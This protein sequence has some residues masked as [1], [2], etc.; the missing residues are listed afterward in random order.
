MKCR[1]HGVKFDGEGVCEKCLEEAYLEGANRKEKQKRLTE[2]AAELTELVG[3]DVEYATTAQLVPGTTTVA[4]A[5]AS[6]DLGA[7]YADLRFVTLEELQKEVDEL[8]N[9]QKT[10]D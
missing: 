4:I 9:E 1:K 3:N 7:I 5:E 6:R 2:L 8:K 10:E